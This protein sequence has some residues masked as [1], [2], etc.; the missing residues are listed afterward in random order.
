MG[1][2]WIKVDEI[3]EHNHEG[4]GRQPSRNGRRRSLVNGPFHSFALLLLELAVCQEM[5]MFHAIVYKMVSHG[6]IN[7]SSSTE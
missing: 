7:Y 1:I 6:I 3:A 4:E 2:E 5:L